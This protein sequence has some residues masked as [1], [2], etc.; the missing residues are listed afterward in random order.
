MLMT[1]PIVVATDFSAGA[2]IGLERAARLAQRWQAPLYV[3]HVFDD[4]IL[5][6]LASFFQ[7][8][9]SAGSD[10]ALTTRQSLSELTNDLAQRYGIVAHPS[11]TSGAAA[12]E[13]ARFATE[14]GAALLVVGQQGEHWIADAV[15]GGTALK[16]AKS[17][18]L[19]VLV[20]SDKGQREINRVLIA[21]DFSANAHRAVQATL[22][23][24]PEAD[25]Q[26]LNAYSV[27]FEG[28]MRM[29][30]AS[31]D[32]IAAYRNLER[33]RAEGEMRNFAEQ[34]GPAQYLSRALVCDFP[35]AAVLKA[36]KEADLV[37]VGRHGGSDIGE[38]LLG[39]VTRNVLYH[40]NCDVL[41]VP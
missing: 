2:G 12:A 26:L 18:A 3:V 30:G 5:A 28:R 22:R 7:S 40:A 9:A 25:K 34:L 39:S 24:F 1:A 14:L 38:L 29:A 23:L 31:D 20:A 27:Q 10:P 19:P 37:V 17:V 4:G 6:S 32:D 21:T 16:L 8:A 15:L 13:I 41:L 33:L 35:A 36:A 11:S